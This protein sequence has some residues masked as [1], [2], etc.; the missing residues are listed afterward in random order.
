MLVAT[1]L[2]HLRA[3]V[4]GCKMQYSNTKYGCCHLENAVCW[5]V[6]RGLFFGCALFAWPLLLTDRCEL[7]PCSDGSH[8]IMPTGDAIQNCCPENY[9]C[10]ATS[11]YSA[12]CVPPSQPAPNVSALQVMQSCPC[13]S[14]QERGACRCGSCSSPP[15]LLTHPFVPHDSASRS[16]HQGRSTLRTTQYTTRKTSRAA[17]SSATAF[18][19]VTRPTLSLH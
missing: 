5:Y 19:S 1:V 16:A 10:V 17:S 9:K 6:T 13:S 3:P 11:V 8:T 12:V 14:L 18:P 2:A 15:P 4:T 7:A